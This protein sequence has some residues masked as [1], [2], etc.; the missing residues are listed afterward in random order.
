MLYIFKSIHIYDLDHRCTAV[1]A[2]YGSFLINRFQIVNQFSQNYI[3]KSESVYIMR[4]FIQHSYL[5]RAL[6][7]VPAKPRIVEGDQ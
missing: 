4:V 1:V 3:N 5:C 2:K 6:N 7:P